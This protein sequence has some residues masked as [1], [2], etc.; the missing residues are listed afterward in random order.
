MSE[1]TIRDVVR[2]QGHYAGARLLRNFG[3]PMEKVL[4]ALFGRAPR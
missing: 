3:V 1:Q 4:F 2:H